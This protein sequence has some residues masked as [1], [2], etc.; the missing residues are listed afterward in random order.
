MPLKLDPNAWEL[1]D[2]PTSSDWW[3][4]T[5]AVE[6]AT[7]GSTGSISVPP[8]LAIRVTGAGGGEFTAHQLKQLAD[9]GLAGLSSGDLGDATLLR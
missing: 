1:A 9:A 8:S 7:P 6:A 3:L 5:V 2:G 4:L